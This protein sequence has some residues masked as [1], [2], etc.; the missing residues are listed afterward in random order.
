MPPAA[1]PDLISRDYAA[2]LKGTDLTVDQVDTLINSGLSSYATKSYVDAQDALLATKAYIDT[3]DALRVS[4]AQKDVANGVAGL[5]AV[6]KVNPNR[7]NLPSTQVFNRGPWSPSAYNATPVDL[8]A[9]TTLFT[10][11][12]T[13]PGYPYKLL[14]FGLMDVRSSVATEYPIIKVRDGSISGPVVAN[15]FSLQDSYNLP[16]VYSDNFDA[17]FDSSKWGTAPGGLGNFEISQGAV[18]P[19]NA[20]MT[21]SQWVGPQP[22]SDR[23]QMKFNLANIFFGQLSVYMSGSDNWT[24]WVCLVLD[25]PQFGASATLYSGTGNPVNGTYVNRGAQNIGA[26]DNGFFDWQI[27]TLDYNPTTNTYT[28]QI[29]GGNRIV[30]TDSGN[31]VSHGVGH[32]RFAIGPNST[33]GV[34]AFIGMGCD[35]FSVTEVGSNPAYSSVRMIPIATQSVR[36]GPTTLYVRGVRSGTTATITASATQ[37]KLFVQAVPA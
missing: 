24:N 30:W 12:V 21:L 34:G 20:V 15:G 8:T 18:M 1:N 27:H 32:R 13:D 10:C 2:G 36:T 3:Q 6:S 16:N 22:V 28:Y 35:N 9:E 31:V 25:R 11:P 37:P 19:S 23:Q 33:Y 17:G 14:V 7:I 4:L 5:D 26:T 29:N